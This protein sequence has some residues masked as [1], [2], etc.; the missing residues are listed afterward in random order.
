MGSGL[1]E[2]R[3]GLRPNW[4]QFTLLVA[5]NA[6]VGALVGMERSILP[7]V[8]G[9]EFGIASA[10]AATSFIAA[11]GP[12]KALANLFAGRLAERFGRRRVLIVGWLVGLPVPLLVIWAP[13]WG[14]IVAANVL[15]GINQ[16]LAWSMTVNMKIDLVGPARRGLALGLNEAAGYL[17]VGIAAL[18]TGVLAEG[19]G[20]RPVPFYVGI[21][22]A[23][24][25]TALSVLFVRETTAHVALE[26]SVGAR[27][28]P[29][30]GAATAPSLRRSFADVSWRRPELFGL[31]QAGLVNNLND[32]LAWGILPLFLTARGLGLGEVAV[33]AAVYPAVW[34]AL[35][36]VT[37]WMS[38][39]LGRR[40]LIVAGM[41]V[42]GAAIAL[43]AFAPGFAWWLT[44]AVALGI[45]TALV[46]PTLL[47]AVGDAVP[48]TDRATALG[49]YRFWR[50]F[51]T[52]IG[53][54]GA[55]A[56]ADLL[57]FVPAILAVAI[58]TAASGVIAAA[59]VRVRTPPGSVPLRGREAAPV[60]EGD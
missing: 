37:G 53:A 9:E 35:Q 7:V 24:A 18:L 5:V 19:F 17:S 29:R 14:W 16:G 27:G 38:D 51:G 47:A 50:D 41:L 3:L 60:A 40:P 30:D 32:G 46:Y 2:P 42:Q 23:A 4:Q 52:M 44:A 55:G 10:A 57:G 39:R 43:V 21:A 8:A 13:S 54:L 28:D 48:A 20:L 25:G 45:G 58:L 36:T 56:V 26:A 22:A 33:L 31:S 49:V 11:F 59:T 12:A 34:G 6:F 15:L 1:V